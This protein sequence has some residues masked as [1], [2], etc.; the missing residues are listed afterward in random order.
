MALTSFAQTACMSAVSGRMTKKIRELYFKALLRQDITFFDK[1]DQGNLLS[2]CLRTFA[3]SIIYVRD[4]GMEQRI[5]TLIVHQSLL[6]ISRRTLIG[7]LASSIMETT[8]V[9]QDGLGEKFA[10]AVQFVSSFVFGLAVALY[11][12]W[13]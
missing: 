1:H 2:C 3:A 13:Q 11:Y 8:M 12:S 7:S 6:T 9:I 4:C 5:R 10:L